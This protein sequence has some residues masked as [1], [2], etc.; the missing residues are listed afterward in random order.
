[1]SEDRQNELLSRIEDLED[2]TFDEERDEIEN[3]INN[4]ELEE[5]ES[6]IDELESERGWEKLCFIKKILSM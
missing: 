2:V 4:G 6:L 1:M 5:A 3:L